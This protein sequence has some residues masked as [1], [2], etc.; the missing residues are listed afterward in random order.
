[1]KTDETAILSFNGGF[2]CAQAVLTAYCGKYNMDK[3]AANKIACGFGA[4]CAR[5]SLTCGAVTGAYMVIGLKYGKS[6]SGD[7]E[8]K[9][10]TYKEV[11]MFS[12]KFKLMHKSINCSE[13]LGAD[14]GTE[15]G[16]AFAKSNDLSNKKCVNFVKDAC[17]ILN[18]MGY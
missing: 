16:R 2:N 18:E 8:P 6:D 15:K 3:T 9:E 13:L 7:D 14:L 17:T 5:Q 11:K 1:M 10:V 12:E 4:G